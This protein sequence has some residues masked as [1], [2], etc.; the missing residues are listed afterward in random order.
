MICLIVAY[1]LGNVIGFDGG[2]PWDLPDD[3][4]HFKK[5]TLGSV[6]IMGRR[7]FKEIYKKF[8]RGLSG[9]E[10]IV[11]SKTQNYEG[12]NYRTVGTLQDAI[13]LSQEL[14]QE[15][16]IFICGGEAVYREA[17]ESGIVEKLYITEIDQEIKG[18][19]F[20]PEFDKN[21]FEIKEKRHCEVPLPHTFFTLVKK[22]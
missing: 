6:L 20:F 4:E 10:T 9:R 16:N 2:I 8:G 18:D 13:K 21:S 22:S 12:E 14:F 3:R 17:M 19:A 15:K 1:S 7:T 11:I 5:L